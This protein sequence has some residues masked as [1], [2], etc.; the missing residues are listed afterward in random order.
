MGTVS[1]ALVMFEKIAVLEHE[2]GLSGIAKICGYDKATTRRFLVELEAHGFI[3]QDAETRKYRIGAAPLR[4][5]R[6]REAR[7]PFLR[8]AIPLLRKLAEETGETVHIAELS[9][10]ALVSLHVEDS[11][12]ANRV[13]VDVGMALPFHATASGLAYLAFAPSR[14]VDSILARPL[15]AF[16]PQTITDPA[17]LKVELGRIRARGY[18]LVRHG[19]ELGVTSIGAP[20]VNASGELIGTL[21]IAAPE[22]RTPEPRI[23]E[24]ASQTT[25]TARQIAELLFGRGGQR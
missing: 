23:A 22:M 4:F 10:D 3:E 8:T 17:E 24:L 7:F 11:V 18:S 1:K 20:I 5:A 12:M 6:I 21:A 19:L 14:L 15:E 13:N 2:E 9:G 16:T 25:R